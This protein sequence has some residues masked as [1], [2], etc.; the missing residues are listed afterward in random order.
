MQPFSAAPSHP[1]R[2]KSGM[3]GNRGGIP[4][5]SENPVSKDPGWAGE[6]EEV[7]YFKGNNPLNRPQPSA[8]QEWNPRL[9]S[10]R[11]RGKLGGPGALASEGRG[12]DGGGSRA[13]TSSRPRPPDQPAPRH[14][15]ASGAGLR[16]TPF[17]P[18][19]PLPCPPTFSALPGASGA[20]KGNT[21]GCHRAP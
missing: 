13:A 2:R 9:R 10:Q 5:R 11:G 7:E 18:P 15:R 21:P 19:P 3:T 14:W 4:G 16:D 8:L 12:R 20:R 6:P 1:Q 17:S